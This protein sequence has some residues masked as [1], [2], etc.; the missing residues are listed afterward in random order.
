MHRYRITFS[1]SGPTRYISH[2]DLAQVWERWF[3]RARIPVTYSQGFNPQPKINLGSALPLGI[4]GENELLD[5]RLTEGTESERIVAQLQ[6]H[7]PP[8]LIVKI[9]KGIDRSEPSIQ[10]QLLANEYLIEHAND[11][12]LVARIND[13]LESADIIRHRR[14]KEYNLRPLIEEMSLDPTDNTL[15]MRLSARPAA[16]GR[17]DEVL[18]ELG[19]DPRTVRIKRTRLVLAD[20]S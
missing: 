18:D 5:V 17:P 16:T 2:L 3:R 8:G 11:M 6:D 12:D 20:I 15:R 19:V 13:L 7:A 1:K 10:S 9:V 14:G 4:E